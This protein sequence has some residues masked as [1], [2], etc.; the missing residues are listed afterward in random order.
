MTSSPLKFCRAFTNSRVFLPKSVSITRKNHGQTLRMNSLQGS[1]N[2]I[3]K[4]PKKEAFLSKVRKGEARLRYKKYGQLTRS[5]SLPCPA[6]RNCGERIARLYLWN[7]IKPLTRALQKGSNRSCN[8]LAPTTH[9]CGKCNNE[10]FLDARYNN[11]PSP[12]QPA[13]KIN[14]HRDN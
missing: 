12:T 14:E 4:C 11:N 6:P 2:L 9:K 7:D 10:T 5:I 3:C 8:A 1:A 13:R